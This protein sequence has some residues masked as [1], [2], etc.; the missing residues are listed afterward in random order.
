M[1]AGEFSSS[2]AQVFLDGGLL[3]DNNRPIGTV[4]PA[5]QYTLGSQGAAGT[6]LWHGGIAEVIV[7]DIALSDADRNTVLNYLDTKYAWARLTKNQIAARIGGV[8]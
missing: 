8:C 3:L 2:D 5:T 7:Y 1:L 4:D 6:D